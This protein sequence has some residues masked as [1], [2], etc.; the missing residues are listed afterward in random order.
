MVVYFAV[1]AGAAMTDLLLTELFPI[2]DEE[3]LFISPV[4]TDWAPVHQRGIEVIIDLEGTLDQGVSTRPGHILYIYHHIYD[5][6]LPDLGTPACSRGT[7]GPA[8]PQRPEGAGPLQHGIQSLGARCGPHSDRIGIRGCGRARP[9]P[10]TAPR[11]TVQRTVRRISGHGTCETPLTSRPVRRV[12]SLIRKSMTLSRRTFLGAGVSLVTAGGATT[13]LARQGASGGAGPIR[14]AVSTYSYW[15]FRGEPYPVERVIEDAAGL[16]F[17]GVEILHRQ[18]ADESPAY[19][20][21]LK[22]TAFRHGVPLVMLSIHQDFVDPD[23]AKRQTGDRSHHPVS[24]ARGAPR[25]S[26]H[27]AELRSLEHDRLI[28]R[29][30]E[31]ER[32]GAAQPR[33]HR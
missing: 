8:C 2:D 31:G 13:S 16:G 30:D 9:A 11:C 5:E 7:W 10:V 3:R 33:P 18:M 22:Q 17:D 23:P 15:H 24:R 1:L 28:R 20:T 14:L 6:E 25:H 19:V 26:V 27:Q 21:R 29:P 12:R 32:A 4:I